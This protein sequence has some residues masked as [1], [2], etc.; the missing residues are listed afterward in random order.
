LLALTGDELGKHANTKAL[1][2][3]AMAYAQM[4]FVGKSFVNASSGHVIKVTRQGLKHSLAG[5]NEIEIRLIPALPHMLSHA[6]HVATEPDKRGR[7]DILSVNKYETRVTIDQE[8]LHV[9]IITRQNAAGHEHYDT[10]V[11]SQK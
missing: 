5:T 3:A 10:F 6:K 9:G 1:R 7:P 4:H 2:T 11:V 8:T